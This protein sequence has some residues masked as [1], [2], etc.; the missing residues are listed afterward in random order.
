MSVRHGHVF[1]LGV[2]RRASTFLID[3][4]GRDIGLSAGHGVPLDVLSDDA[5][6]VKLGIGSIGVIALSG[7]DAGLG[8]LLSAF[9]GCSVWIFW[10]VRTALTL[11]SGSDGFSGSRGVGSF[12]GGVSREDD[13]GFLGA[14]F[15]RGCCGR[16]FFSVGDTA[17]SIGR[18][19]LNRLDEVHRSCYARRSFVTLVHVIVGN[20][21]ALILLCCSRLGGRLQ[22]YTI[23]ELLFEAKPRGVGRLRIREVGKLSKFFGVN[24]RGAVSFTRT[25]QEF[26]PSR[27][28]VKRE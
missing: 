27:K 3:S 17:F 10:L 24:L 20:T 2:N 6:G 7:R 23:K 9:R 8:A 13:D 12:F 22:N 4:L 11:R 16:S 21:L 1:F 28:Q 15:L 14:P 26:K 18:F 25:Q 19:A 5:T